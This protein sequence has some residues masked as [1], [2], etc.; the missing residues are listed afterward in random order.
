M[1]PASRCRY[2]DDARQRHRKWGPVH[3]YPVLVAA[4]TFGPERGAERTHASVRIN[5]HQLEHNLRPHRP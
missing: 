5:A 3:P 2:I 1:S 4:S